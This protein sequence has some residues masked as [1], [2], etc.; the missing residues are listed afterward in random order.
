MQDSQ[1]QGVGLHPLL[2]LVV[3]RQLRFHLGPF[4]LFVVVDR[5][6]DAV[7]HVFVVGQCCGVAGQLLLLSTHSRLDHHSSSRSW[8]AAQIVLQ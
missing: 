3:Q 5:G 6:H 4:Q 2:S 8:N 7:A 1:L